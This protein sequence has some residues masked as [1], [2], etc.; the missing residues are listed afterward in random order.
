[1][2]K[3][4]TEAAFE[5]YDKPRTVQV[6]LWSM[7]IMERVHRIACGVVGKKDVQ[8]FDELDERIGF[9]H[10]LRHPEMSTA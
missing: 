10:S 7:A 2:L 8:Y 4:L 6:A 1:L 3:E 5:A 9:R